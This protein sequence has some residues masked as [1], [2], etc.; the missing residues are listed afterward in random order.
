MNFIIQTPLDEDVS[1][2]VE[3]PDKIDMSVNRQI[4]TSQLVG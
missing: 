3:S 4:D 2:A 1:P